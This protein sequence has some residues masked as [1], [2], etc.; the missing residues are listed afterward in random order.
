MIMTWFNDLIQELGAHWVIGK[1]P[2]FFGLES[3]R[4]G[5]VIPAIKTAKKGNLYDAVFGLDKDKQGEALA[6][7]KQRSIFEKIN[8]EKTY[9]V[10]Q[11]TR[12]LALPPEDR[13]QYIPT[14]FDENFE[15]LKQDIVTRMPQLNAV[16]AARIDESFG[17]GL[18]NEELR[19]RKQTNQGS[20]T[21]IA[22]EASILITAILGLLLWAIL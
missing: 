17:W 3:G 14:T 9:T 1:F 21:R 10:V 8:M 4:A 12:I 20:P 13:V 19:R 2:R 18:R 7:I 16:T 22:I 5:S 15:K 6:W 11:L